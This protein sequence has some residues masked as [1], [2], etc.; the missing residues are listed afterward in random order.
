MMSSQNIFDEGFPSQ[1]ASSYL[2]SLMGVGVLREIKVG[3][4]KLSLHPKHVWL[5][6]R[7]TTT[8]AH[9]QNLP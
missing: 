7:E 9:T 3:R 2:K 8:S 6:T 4:K 1:I 5:L